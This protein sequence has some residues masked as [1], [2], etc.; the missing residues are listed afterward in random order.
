MHSFYDNRL[1]EY[2]QYFGAVPNI[3]E[4]IF[5]MFFNQNFQGTIS[6][7]YISKNVFVEEGGYRFFI[8]LQIEIDDDVRCIQKVT[9]QIENDRGE[10]SL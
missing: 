6:M 9:E 4:S 7:T 1:C 10:C 5:S 2:K 3:G 8:L